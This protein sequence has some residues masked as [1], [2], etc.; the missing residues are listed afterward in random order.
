MI[1]L[2]IDIPDKPYYQE[3]GEMLPYTYF[4]GRKCKYCMTPF[5]DHTNKSREFCEKRVFPDGRIIDCKSLYWTPERRQES[6]IEKKQQE[7]CRSF[8]ELAGL[9]KTEM[10][11]EEFCTKGFSFNLSKQSYISIENKMVIIFEDGHLLIDPSTYN[12]KIVK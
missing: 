2:K 6:K 4:D 3:M 7:I 1:K 12:I 11:W 8:L 9:G 5:P 10:S